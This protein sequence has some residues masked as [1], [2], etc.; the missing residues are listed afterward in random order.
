MLRLLRRGDGG[1][2][3]QAVDSPRA[4][5]CARCGGMT[6]DPLQGIRIETGAVLLRFEGGSRESWSS[7]F[8]F[9]YVPARG[10]WR[11]TS[12][13]HRGLDRANGG[14]SATRT[15]STEEIGD[16]PLG[17]FEAGDFRADALP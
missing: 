8:R 12:V 11:L 10:D 2:L 16:V 13:V 3:Q 9:E 14:K 5:L 7:E 1:R 17:T 15:L 4:I 6:G